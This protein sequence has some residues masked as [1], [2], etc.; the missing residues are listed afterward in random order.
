MITRDSEQAETILKIAT[1]LFAAL[2]YDGTSTRQ[3]AD[4]AGLNV[5]TVNYHVGGKRELYLAVMERAHHTERTALEEATAALAAASPADAP[6]ALHRLL[7][8]YVDLCVEHPE[9]PSLWM[10]R[11]LSDA[12]DITSLEQEYVQPLVNAIGGALSALPI[13]RDVDV[14]YALW[15]VIW[16]VNGFARGGVLDAEGRRRGAGDARAVRRFRAHLHLMV[17]RMLGLP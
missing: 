14:E 6:A 10:H 9:I 12:G 13:D 5:A 2:G 7:D 3:I 4:A 17:Q 11:W 8:R 16:C 1:Q 15:S